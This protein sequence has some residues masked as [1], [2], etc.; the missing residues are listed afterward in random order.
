MLFCLKAN[1][2]KLAKKLILYH[3]NKIEGLRNFTTIILKR[4]GLNLQVVLESQRSH[5]SSPGDRCQT[6]SNLNWIGNPSSFPY[7]NVRI[8]MFGSFSSDPGEKAYAVTEATLRTRLADSPVP[9]VK[10]VRYQRLQTEN[11]SSTPGRTAYSLQRSLQ[12]YRS[13]FC[14]ISMQVRSRNVL[15]ISRNGNPK[16]KPR[17]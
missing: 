16:L 7:S 10:A 5:W 1:G 14:Y 13:N 3:L 12:R 2:L 4:I 6:K 11:E 9:S 17:K 8:F 15:F